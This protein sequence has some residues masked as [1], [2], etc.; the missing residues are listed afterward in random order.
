VMTSAAMIAGM[1]PAALGLGAGGRFQGD[2]A[3][4]V[5][6]GLVTSTALTLVMV[7]A[8]F[9]WIDDAERWV[10]RLFA[11]GIG[12]REGTPRVVISR[13]EPVADSEHA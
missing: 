5:I 4:A 1:L 3:I 11:R 12:T 8:V 9:T 13:T 2:M 6:G 10:G 7:P